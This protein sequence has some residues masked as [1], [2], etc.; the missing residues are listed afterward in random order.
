MTN[1]TF[2]ARKKT[3]AVARVASADVL[4]FSYICDIW[5]RKCL[6]LCTCL[7]DL[8]VLSSTHVW[9]SWWTS[10]LRWD[11]KGRNRFEFEIR[12]TLIF[13][14]MVVTWI[15]YL[16]RLDQR[17]AT[18]SFDW[19]RLCSW[20]VG[21]LF[22]RTSYVFF[23]TMKKQICHDLLFH[24]QSSSSSHSVTVGSLWRYVRASMSLSG[25]FPP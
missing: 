5:S 3:Y 1:K 18:N 12:S 7:N 19:S 24:H 20:T 25:Y 23:P 16:V 4:S 22:S 2:I 17:L 21:F 13:I 9:S 15:I 8:C 6:A 11:N 10:A 14:Q